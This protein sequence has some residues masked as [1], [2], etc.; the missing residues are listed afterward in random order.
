[1]KHVILITLILISEALNAQVNLNY[2]EIITHNN[3]GYYKLYI[4]KNSKDS[5]YNAKS[6]VIKFRKGKKIVDLDSAVVNNENISQ[7]LNI[8]LNIDN[9]AFKRKSEPCLDGN[10]IRLDFSDDL[11]YNMITQMY[12]CVNN[13]DEIYLSIVKIYNLFPF[14]E[15][16]N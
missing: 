14:K 4:E 13:A 7:L 11:H 3:N 10:T 16:L 6:R 8:V 2:L 15:K 1:M 5:T 9:H 12:Q